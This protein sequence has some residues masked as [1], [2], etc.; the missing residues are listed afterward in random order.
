[1]LKKLCL[2]SALVLFSIATF[3][4][5]NDQS[6]SRTDLNKEEALVVINFNCPFTESGTL[7]CGIGYSICGSSRDELDEINAELECLN[8]ENCEDEN[9]NPVPGN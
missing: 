3:A 5:T 8:C 2:S 9:D 6:E 7:S 1:M 4:K